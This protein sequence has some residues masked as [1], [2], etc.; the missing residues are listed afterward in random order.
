MLKL[1]MNNKEKFMF[2]VL[3]L[4]ITFIEFSIKDLRNYTIDDTYTTFVYA[5]NIV[6]GNGSTYNVGEFSSAYTPLLT[7]V[8]AFFYMLFRFEDPLLFLK[9]FN[10]ILTFL[11]VFVSYFLVSKIS[12]KRIAF[13]VAILIATNPF[14]NLF[15]CAGADTILFILFSLLTIY[16]YILKKNLLASALSAFT[17][18]SRPEGAFLFLLILVHAT[19]KE[20]SLKTKWTRILKDRLIEIFI[21]LLI[22]SPWLLFLL[23]NQGTIFATSVSGKRI[24]YERFAA[25]IGPIKF[26]YLLVPDL[27]VTIPIVFIAAFAFITRLNRN[28][29]LKENFL[30]DAWWIM[31]ILVHMFFAFSVHTY[32]YLTPAIPFVYISILLFLERLKKAKIDIIS[33]SFIILLLLNLGELYFIIPRAAEVNSFYSSFFEVS[34]WIINNTAPSDRIA[35]GELGIIKWVTGRYVVDVAGILNPDASKFTSA[36]SFYYY[37]KISNAKYFIVPTRYLDGSNPLYE[38]SRYNRL[39]E[40]DLEFSGVEWTFY[41]VP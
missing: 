4:L 33:I 41:E 8:F 10:L 2:I 5:K 27:L 6:E 12:N 26:S 31:I 15:S 32:R 38:K 29:V 30:I 11:A 9:I 37:L 24:I 7:F 1:K 36:D 13:L 25:S 40:K 20:V 23:L 21:F 18:L 22:S 16:A 14:I 19:I 35:L 34:E 28:D 17:F 39:I 3:F